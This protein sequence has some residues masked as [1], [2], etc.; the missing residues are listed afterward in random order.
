MLLGEEVVAA[1]VCD[2]AAV[3]GD[4]SCD[5]LAPGAQRADRALL[6]VL[7]QPGV[8]GDVGAQDRRESAVSV[9]GGHRATLGPAGRGGQQNVSL[10]LAGPPKSLARE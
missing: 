4:Q 1:E 9:Y 2:A 8:A 7:H 3:L 10:L 6:V 5:L